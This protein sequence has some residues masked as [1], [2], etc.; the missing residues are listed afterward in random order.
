MEPPTSTT[1]SICCGCHSGVGES[2]FAGLHGAL[3]DVI[4]HVLEAGPGQPHHQVLGTGGVR[5][6]ERQ[7]DLGFEH[8]WKARSSPF[9]R[10]LQPLQRHLVFRQIDPVLLAEL[11]DDPVDQAL[12]DVV[13]AQVGVAVGRFDLDNAVADLQDRDVEGAAAEIEYRD[14]LVLLLVQP[15]GQRGRRRLIDDA[16]Y[17]KAGNLAG[18]LGRLPLRI[19]EIRRDGNHGGA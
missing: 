7:I 3:Q 1:S 11:P 13:A 10:F 6:D 15:V 12:V 9:R 19:V 16:L 4:D 14:G 18:V 2:L 17:F 5:R 8:A